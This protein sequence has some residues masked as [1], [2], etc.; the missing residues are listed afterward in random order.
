MSHFF[1][2]FPAQLKNLRKLKLNRN[3]LK[4]SLPHVLGQLQG[5]EIVYAVSCQIQHVPKEVW[6]CQR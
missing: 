1:F 4:T 6:D 2:P 3:P 5:L